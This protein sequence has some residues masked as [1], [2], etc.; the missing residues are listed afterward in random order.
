[1]PLPPYTVANVP[2]LVASARCSVYPVA[3]D[4]AFHD[5]CADVSVSCWTARPAG[6]PIGVE[7]VESSLQAAATARMAIAAIWRASAHPHR[8]HSS[9]YGTG[10]LQ[11]CQPMPAAS[12]DLSWP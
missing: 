11:G 6:E 9:R 8:S 2:G 1:V 7:V 3:P 12:S 5:T 4:T 10:S